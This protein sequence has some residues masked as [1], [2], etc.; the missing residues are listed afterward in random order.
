MGDAAMVSDTTEMTS[1]GEP[2]DRPDIDLGAL[3][4]SRCGRW[5]IRNVPETGSTNADL[6]AEGAAGAAGG[7]VLV[8]DFQHG[9]RGR[10]DRTW[11]SPPRAGLTFSVLVD[12]G[13]VPPARWAWLPLLSG[14]AVLEAARD[15]AGVDAVLKWPNDLLVGT[16]RLKACGILVQAVPGRDQAVIGIGLNVTTTRAELPVPTSTSLL[17]EG[18][19]APDRGAL[20]DG[21]LSALAPRLDAWVAAGGDPVASGLHAQ[22]VAACATVSQAVRVSETSGAEWTG[23]ATGVDA[24]GRLEVLGDDG[25]A[26]A[27]GAGDVVHVRP[28]S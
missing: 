7:A 9:G 24:E 6:L 15:E 20:L 26:R 1:A 17:L 21:V 28:A 12:C 3:R 4:S 25:S 19:V 5:L 23:T 14:L 18:A 16:Q 22:Y 11:T 10:L 2:P 8:A 13:G 27:V